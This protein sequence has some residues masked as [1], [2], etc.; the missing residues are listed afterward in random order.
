[1][2]TTHLTSVLY[3]RMVFR[4]F[5]PK[6][7]TLFN[8]NNVIIRKTPEMAAPTTGVLFQSQVQE[9]QIKFRSRRV[10]PLKNKFQN[11]SRLSRWDSLFPN[12]W[13]RGF[14]SI[15]VDR[16]R[17]LLCVHCIFNRRKPWSFESVI[18]T[19]YSWG[20]RNWKILGRVLRRDQETP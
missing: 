11:H 9:Y 19:D 16:S 18:W 15:L 13:F 7:I 12:L 10:F 5:L 17:G 20:N 6:F 4:S 1:M 3:V 14:R 8:N 2:G